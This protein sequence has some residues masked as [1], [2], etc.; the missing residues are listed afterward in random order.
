MTEKKEPDERSIEISQGNYNESINRDYV[1][2]DVYYVN[3]QP[4]VTP[5]EYRNRQALLNKVN[6]FWIKGVLERSL[7]SQV[8]IDL[9]LEERPDAVVQPW[10]MVLQTP[11]EEPKPL[12]E[13][14]KVVDLFDAIGV[15]RTLL[16]LGE[17]GSGK[18]TTLLELTRDLILRAKQDDNLLIP[19][20]LNLSSWA[21][22]RQKIEDWLVEELGDKYD[23]PKAIREPLVKKQKLLP[24]LDG[25]DEVKVQYREECIVALNQ[26]K[27]DYGSELVVCSRIKDYEALT[28]RLNFQCAVYLRLLTI[29]KVHHYL[30]SLGSDVTGLNTLVQEDK[31]LQELAQSPLM[32][33]IMTLAYQGVAVEDLYTTNLLE[34]RRIK[35]FDDYIEKVLNRPNR[36]KNQTKYSKKQIKLWLSWLAKKMSQESSTIFLIERM[37]PTCLNKNTNKFF[38][39][40]IYLSIEVIIEVFLIALGCWAFFLFFMDAELMQSVIKIMTMAGIFLFISHYISGTKII[41]SNYTNRR[42]NYKIKPTEKLS[43]SWAKVVSFW[44][45]ER[46]IA[47]YGIPVV[48]LIVSIFMYL[49]SHNFLLVVFTTVMIMSFFIPFSVI[50]GTVEA[51]KI[52]QK[53]IPNQGIRKS[54]I[55]IVFLMI[56]VYPFTMILVI[57]S[58]YVI[59]K[60]ILNVALNNI[61]LIPPALVSS[62]FFSFLFAM[63]ESGKPVI[64]HL[65]LRIILWV[66]RF[67]PWNYARFLDYATDRIFLQK[68]GGGYI[69]I[70]RMLMEHFA[71][72]E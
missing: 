2:G 31:V 26:F 62:L 66:N 59:W 3:N 21:N 18:T 52:E 29:E 11:N 57:L 54:I 17:P 71:Q 9:G 48:L 13:G 36:S 33:N 68:V 22:K 24:L 7:H 25:L 50:E 53:I 37:Q 12:P 35:L 72:I 63:I 46:K 70:H 49:V 28:N 23:V 58:Q 55:N 20:V 14:T 1:Q 39:L 43:F 41:P 67:I 10:N 45:S 64:Q 38:Y 5:Q 51:E 40:L 42:E 56:I 47:V 15:G 44:K 6:N 61:Y 8:L 16:I 69:F 27:Q 32:L 30:D 19:V 4:S 34:E 65:S 60:I